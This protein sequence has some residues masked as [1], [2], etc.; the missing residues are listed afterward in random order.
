VA[1]GTTTTRALEGYLSGRSEILSSNGAVRGLTD[2]FI[3]E[4]YRP[5]AVDGLITN[6]HL[7][8]STPLMLASAFAGRERLLL[9]YKSAI[10]MGY[11][12][13]SYG[14]AMLVL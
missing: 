6:F 1:V 10:S 5:K 4:G 9:A 7:P 11:R 14:D 13:F 2:I 8:R 3:H 12:F